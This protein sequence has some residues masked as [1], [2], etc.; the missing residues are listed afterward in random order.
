LKNAEEVGERNTQ[1]CKENGMTVK[2][3]SKYD[4]LYVALLTPY[5]DNT[6]DIDEKQLRSLIRL[7]LQP[8]YVEAGMGIIINP[9]AGEIFYL[10]REE[11]RRNVEIALEEVNGKVPVF[12]GA[13]DITTAG[14]V[15]VALDAKKAGVDGIFLIPPIGAGDVTTTWD[16]VKYPEVIV[17]LAKEIVKAVGDM[18]MIVH[19]TGTHSIQYGQGLPVE[20]VLKMVTEIKNIVGWKMTYNYTGYRIVSRALRKLDR[21]VGVLAA[22]S[23][24]FHENLA[25]G[26]FDGTVTGSFN[27][28]LEGMIDHIQ[29]WRRK[30]ID[31]ARRLWNAGQAELHEYMYSE[32]SRLHVRYK[33]GAWLRGFISNPFMRPP[34]PKPRKEEVQKVYALL[35]NAGLSVIEKTGV[36]RII[37]SLEL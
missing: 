28:G 14:T 3:E 21:R 1:G 23:I 17:D 33:I 27:Y 19:P 31:E 26:V 36:D 8:K 18:P 37:K 7:F 32:F 35:L 34:M 22:S 24:Y 11:K 2:T 29:A 30:D 16:P 6:Y 15:Q 25:S 10:T 13:I 12:A 20:T 4:R 5:K 9:E